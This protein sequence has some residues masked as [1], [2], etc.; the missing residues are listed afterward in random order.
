MLNS[1]V[2]CLALLFGWFGLGSASAQT[3]PEKPIHIIVPFTPGTPLDIIARVIAPKLEEQ[4][5]QRV[6][7]E[8]QAGAGNAVGIKAASRA[9]PDG[10]TLL[11][12][13]QSASSITPFVYDH[14][15]YSI[16]REFTPVHLTVTYPFIM[17]INATL[18]ISTVTEF[19]DF[20]KKSDEPMR[21]G[22]TG[23]AAG[24]NVTTVRFMKAAGISMRPVPYKGGGDITIALQRG[25]VQTY[26][27]V[28]E[29]FVTSTEGGPIRVLAVLGKTRHPS[30]PNVPTL[31]ESG[32]NFSA[33]SW[34]GMVA[35][36]GVPA[37]LVDRLNKEMNI[38]LLSPEVKDRLI[39]LGLTP[40]GGSIDDFTKLMN[41][42]RISWGQVIKEAGIKAE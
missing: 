10:Y 31:I 2:A 15:P 3:Y 21:Y 30:F 20:A 19:I 34:Y 13:G 5:K 39:Q 37:A 32:L 23:P 38:A 18:P 16:E 36:I 17:G 12:I 6:L 33:T 7:I 41:E 1:F 27:G 8:N 42:E 14:P 35:P 40:V 11:M 9:K 4:L 22:T 26:I 24:S 29:S 28:P 25:D